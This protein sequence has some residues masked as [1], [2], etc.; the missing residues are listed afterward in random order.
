MISLGTKE[1]KTCMFRAFLGIC[2][3]S[4]LHNAISKS[5]KRDDAEGSRG[6][7]NYYPIATQSLKSTSG[8][9]E[10]TSASY[11]KIELATAVLIDCIRISY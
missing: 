10:R 2:A 1:F 4:S 7:F 5:R 3:I 11:R 8:A 9:Y 6:L